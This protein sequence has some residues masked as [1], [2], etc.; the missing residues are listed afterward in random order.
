V[1]EEARADARLLM[2]S[3]PRLARPEHARLRRMV[4]ARYGQVLELS[5]VG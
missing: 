5:D 1:L 3:D 4:M 2:E